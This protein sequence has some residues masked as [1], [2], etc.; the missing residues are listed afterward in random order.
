MSNH[1]KKFDERTK[2]PQ[3]IGGALGGLIKIFGVRAS[4]S[5]LVARWGEIMGP[6]IAAVAQL[7]AIKKN[8]DGTFNVVIRPTHPAYALQLSYQSGEITN[9]INKYFGYDAVGKISFRK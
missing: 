2:R 5:D 6:D 7:A 8:R 3:T 9:R 4:D 1:D